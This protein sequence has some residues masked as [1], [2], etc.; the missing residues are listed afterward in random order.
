MPNHIG[1]P[2]I[3]QFRVACK[4]IKLRAEYVGRDENGDPIYDE[5]KPKPVIEFSGT[6][7]LHGT[8]AS[9]AYN[10]RDGLWCQSREQIITPQKDN[11]GFARFVEDNRDYLTNFMEESMIWYLGD[12][13]PE[14]TIDNSTIV[15]Y[16]EWVGQGIQSGVGISQIPKSFFVFGLKGVSVFPCEPFVVTGSTGDLT[17]NEEI[18]EEWLKDVKFYTPKTHERIFCIE[19]YDSYSITVDFNHP[20][21]VS[22]DLARL[23]EEVE[24]GCPVAKAFGISGVGEGIVWKAFWNDDLYMFKTKGEKHAVSKTKEIAGVAP[25]VAASVSDFVERTVTQARFSQAI[26]KVCGKPEDADTKMIGN[27][28]KWMAEDIQKEESDTLEASGLTWDDVK[29]EVANKSR[30]M[31]LD[32]MKG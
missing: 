10:K 25:E 7:K 20:E 30:T 14:S 22:E 29:K 32:M 28:L 9:I 23:T 31:F 12:S 15:L 27:F 21:L 3:E 11:A 1:F 6:V 13:I 18:H 24:K 19:D 4:I 2:S 5:S 26:E 17:I 16:G 8:N